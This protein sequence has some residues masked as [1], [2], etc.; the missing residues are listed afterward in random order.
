MKPMYRKPY[1]E[2]IDR[3]YPFLR[4]YKVPEFITFSGDGTQS[5]IEHVG[6]FTVQCGDVNDYVRLR[7]FGNSLTSTAFNWYVFLPPNSIQEWS[8][9]ERI[10]HAQFYRT[11]PEVTMADLARIKQMPQESTEDFITRF[12]RARSKC[13]VQLPEKEFVSMARSGLAFELRKKFEDRDFIDLFQLVS[14]VSKYEQLLKEEEKRRSSSM[15][16]YYRDPNVEV[17]MGELEQ[18]EFDSD[19]EDYDINMAELIVG[20]PYIC[21]A[22]ARPDPNNRPNTTNNNVMRFKNTV[23]RN[24]PE[25]QYAFDITKADQ[26]FDQLLKD[27]QLKLSEGHKLPLAN[28]L[29]GKRYC[30][31]HNAWSHNTS[32]P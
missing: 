25:K 13:F 6:R 7:L 9:L 32:I 5:T 30:K 3:L 15:G 17:H 31:W 20:K 24:Q 26:I 27:K 2:W 1:P 28:E 19:V 4:S 21:R 23:R 11:E 29:Q 18:T 16:T 8:Q 12:K 14:C 10:F 22:L